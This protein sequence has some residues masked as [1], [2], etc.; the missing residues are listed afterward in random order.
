MNTKHPGHPMDCWFIKQTHCDESTE[1][2]DEV[3]SLKTGNIGYEY[4]GCQ[5]LRNGSRRGQRL[6]F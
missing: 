4:S 1:K 2:Y 3:H 5:T 6:L